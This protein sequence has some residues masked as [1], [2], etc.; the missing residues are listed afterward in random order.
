MNPGRIYQ[1]D[2]CPMFSLL[3]GNMDDPE[4][5]IAGGLGLRADNRQ[6]LASECIQQCGFAGVRTTQ[7]TNESRAKGHEVRLDS[8]AADV[9]WKLARARLADCWPVTLPGAGRLLR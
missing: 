8:F 1:D 4:N 7:N 9:L 3:L 6:L 2:L 5:A